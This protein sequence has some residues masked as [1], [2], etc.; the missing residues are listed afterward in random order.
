MLRIRK[1]TLILIGAVLGVSLLAG[2]VGVFWAMN[3]DNDP[4]PTSE[5]STEERED[6]YLAFFWGECS[7]QADFQVLEVESD[8]SGAATSIDESGTEGKERLIQLSAEELAQLKSTLIENNVMSLP[9]EIV[10]DDT[11]VPLQPG[12]SRLVLEMGEEN[13][14]INEADGINP[15]YYRIKKYLIELGGN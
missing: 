5:S 11:V 13:Q 14:L 12:C 4:T 7:E 2:G 9:G 8:G 1:T 6:F 15:E 10:S 3:R